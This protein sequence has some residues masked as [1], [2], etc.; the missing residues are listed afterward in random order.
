MRKGTEDYIAD[1]GKHFVLTEKGAKSKSYEE[2]GIGGI[3]DVFEHYAPHRFIEDG[4]VELENEFN[5]FSINY[6]DW[7]LNYLVVNKWKSLK[8]S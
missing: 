2:L 6:E 1:K 4:K 3:V 5:I 8:F 7:C